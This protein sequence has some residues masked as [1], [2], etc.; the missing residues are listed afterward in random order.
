MTLT[1]KQQA[2]INLSHMTPL[3]VHIRTPEGS[4]DLTP[5]P[6]LVINRYIAAVDVNGVIATGHVALEIRN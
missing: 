2:E 3:T 1:D 6:R 5:R 4:A